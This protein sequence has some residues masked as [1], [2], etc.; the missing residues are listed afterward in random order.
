VRCSCSIAFLSIFQEV[1]SPAIEWFIGKSAGTI[2]EVQHVERS[3]STAE[4]VFKL[5]TEVK[6]GE[7]AA[8]E[9]ATATATATNGCS[10]GH[11]RRKQLQQAED[12]MAKALNACG[13]SKVCE[14]VL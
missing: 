2:V 14:G 4:D 1:E 3:Y 13:W 12:I 8:T 10:P 6:T 9:A 5:P 11:K 7:Q